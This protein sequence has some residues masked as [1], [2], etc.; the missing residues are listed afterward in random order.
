[1]KLFEALLL[2]KSNN[3]GNIVF[4]EI[5]HVYSTPVTV[6]ANTTYTLYDGGVEYFTGLD[7][8]PSKYKGISVKRT[9]FE[10]YLSSVYLYCAY[11]ANSIMELTIINNRGSAITIEKVT[12][13]VI[14]EK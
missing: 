3:A 14:Y 4:E 6:P 8:P 1:M 11:Q 13:T 5:T 9:D 7:I 10:P 12:F 2:N